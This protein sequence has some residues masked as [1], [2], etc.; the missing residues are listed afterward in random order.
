[1]AKRINVATNTFGRYER[2]ET[3]PTIKTL[4]MLSCEL[5]VS[6]DELH[7][8]YTSFMSNLPNE[9]IFI[10]KELNLSAKNLGLLLGVNNARTVR[11]WQNGIRVP[12]TSILKKLIELKKAAI[13]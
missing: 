6:L 8:E 3:Y 1:M 9:V 11:D 5:A 4:E 12:N 10:R 13:K 7:D 2:G